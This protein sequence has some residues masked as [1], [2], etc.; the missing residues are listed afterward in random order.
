MNPSNKFR[1]HGEKTESMNK[2]KIFFIIILVSLFVFRIWQTTG[3]KKF[4]SFYFNPLSIK[5]SVESNVNT[6]LGMDRNISRFF[7][8]KA[9]VGIFE[10]SKSFAS[11]F[12][13]RV[14]LEFLGPAGL[15]L[16]IAA[17][18]EVFKQKKYL[19]K[20]HFAVILIASFIAISTLN[21]KVSFFL[22]AI[23]WY[24]FSLWGIDFFTK[25][26]TAKIA[27]IIL[28]VISFWYFI[29]DW[30]IN[31]ICNEIFFN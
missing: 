4:L 22:L 23:S 15:I 7:H 3:C 31:T 21:S 26:K 24:S 1:V 25:T 30:Q 20:F 17:F 5:V 10:F 11:T 29:F 16:A 14:L 13:P 6:D 8:N 27:F 18:L 12:Q 28:A 9:T 19:R 2:I